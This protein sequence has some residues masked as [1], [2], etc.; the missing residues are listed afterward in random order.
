MAPEW[1]FVNHPITSKVDVYSYGVVVLEMI[2]GRSSAGDQ[3]VESKGRLGSWVKEKMI[4]A[5]GTN[6]WIKEVVDKTVVGSY[7]SSK[8]EILIKVALRCSEEDKDARPTMSQ[9]VDM[10]LHVEDHSDILL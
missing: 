1:L 3:S 9:V 6:D 8:M 7:D 4:A 5:G 10:L 2:T